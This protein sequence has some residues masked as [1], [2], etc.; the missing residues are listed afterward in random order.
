MLLFKSAAKRYSAAPLP[1]EF[2]EF[3]DAVV[4]TIVYNTY[5]Q[6]WK[7]YCFND[8][9]ITDNGMITITISTDFDNEEYANILIQGSTYSITPRDK[10]K[11]FRYIRDFY[12][13]QKLKRFSEYNRY[14]KTLKVPPGLVDSKNVRDISTNVDGIF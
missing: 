8:H 10:R 7:V 14:V 5:H 13:T 4:N 1:K 6:R 11:L 3:E 12:P 2:T 9:I